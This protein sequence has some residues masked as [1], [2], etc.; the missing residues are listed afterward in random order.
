M[1]KL[2]QEALSLPSPKK[3]RGEKKISCAKNPHIILI[4]F[5]HVGKSAIAEALSGKIQ[6]E[7]I[8]LDRRI[9][10]I[11]AQKYGTKLTCREIVETK[12]EAFFRAL[13]QAQLEELIKAPS[14]VIAT[15]GGTPMQVENCALMAP[16]CIVHITAEPKQVFERIMQNGRPAFFSSHEDPWITFQRLWQERDIIYKRIAT[17]SVE[18]NRSIA[19]AVEK[20]TEKLL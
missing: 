5:K 14:C 13:E 2:I 19:A 4:G 20:L 18:N 3:G 15:G 6:K 16:H 17:F 10:G 1:P 12:G 8:D 11:Y 9:E 7:F